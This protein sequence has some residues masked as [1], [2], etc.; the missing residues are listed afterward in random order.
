MIA[1]GIENNHENVSL[2]HSW[3]SGHE[4]FTRGAVPNLHLNIL[5][6]V[7]KESDSVLCFEGLSVIPSELIINNAIK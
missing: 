3:I 5:I 2:L 7:R 1:G 6:K 4:A